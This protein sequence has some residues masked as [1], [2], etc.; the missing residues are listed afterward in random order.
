MQKLLHMFSLIFT[1]VVRAEVIQGFSVRFCF[2]FEIDVIGQN[3][4]SSFSI[5]SRKI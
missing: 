1:E 5:V 2:L 4:L 3:V